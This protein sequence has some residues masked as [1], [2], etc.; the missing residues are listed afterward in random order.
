[1]RHVFASLSSKSPWIQTIL[2]LNIAFVASCGCGSSVNPRRT[3]SATT[4]EQE[5]SADYEAGETKNI[6]FFG[7]SLT[8]GLGLDDPHQAFPGLIQQRIDSLGLPYRVINGGLSG[9]T[10]AGGNERIEW[11]L[12]EEIHVF[13]LELGA[14]DGLR[15][16]PTEQTQ[17]NL[18]S[19]VDKVKSKYPDCKLILAGMM[20]P[21]SMG[22][23]YG[24]AFTALFPALAK[25]NNMA[26]I[27]FLL[28]GVA[29]ETTLNQH[30][31]IHPTEAGHRI[32]AN[33]VWKVLEPML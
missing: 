2:L 19:I 26:L 9:E 4:P 33:N 1:M 16:V 24:K 31:G 32:L 30:D 5:R 23:E 10:S 18:Q 17:K 11:L 12:N 13:V 3:E 29:G 8:A 22:G 20:V 27:P 28:D 15:G 25:E 6:L 21:P 7:N 14:N